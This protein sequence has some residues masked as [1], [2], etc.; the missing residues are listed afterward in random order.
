MV[1]AKRLPRLTPVESSSI[2]GVHYDSA[3]SELYVRF[4]ESGETYVYHL[5]PRR[6]FEELLSA[7][8]KGAYL[9]QQI[10]PS[11]PFSKL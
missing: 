9:N 4:R 1:M 3:T 2:A 6:V 10:K 8:S 11:Y 5:V 7:D